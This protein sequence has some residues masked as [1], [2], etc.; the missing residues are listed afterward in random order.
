[1]ALKSSSGGCVIISQNHDENPKSEVIKIDILQDLAF[2]N[3][4]M[5]DKKR[6]SEEVSFVF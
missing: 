5:G 3:I 1:M 2:K 6:S 4:L